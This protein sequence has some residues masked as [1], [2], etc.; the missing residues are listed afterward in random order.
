[1]TKEEKSAYK[2]A[3]YLDNKEKHS[4]Q[5]KAW[6]LAH[7]EESA[8]YNKAWQKANP[9]KKNANN[10]AYLLRL[11]LMNKNISKRT[12]AAWAV[13]V[14]ERDTS[15]LCCSATDN[16]HAHHILPKINFPH[17]ALLVDNGITL[18]DPCHIQEHIINGD[19]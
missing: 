12:L 4:K 18:C 6:R 1:M 5:M 9:E 8:V 19:I 15:C 16:L 17:Y 10:K 13:Q 7:K 2:K 14:K 3:W 11:N